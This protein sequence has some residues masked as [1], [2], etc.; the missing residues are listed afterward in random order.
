MSSGSGS[1]LA[2]FWPTQESEVYMK[3][4]LLCSVAALA[5]V[6]AG[7]G[8]NSTTEPAAPTS[9]PPASDSHDDHAHDEH[10][11]HAHDGHDEHSHDADSSQSDMAKMTAELAKLSPED[12]ASAEKQHVCPVS[13]EMLGVAGPPQKTHRPGPRGVG[14]LQRLRRPA[15]SES[16]RVSGEVGGG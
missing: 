11:E 4:A 2:H 14:L 6:L 15:P 7:C 16:S 1:Q 13:G 12:R 9:S 3:L 10:A 5:L 8:S